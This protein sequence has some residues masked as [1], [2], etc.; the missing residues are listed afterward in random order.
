[1]IRRRTAADRAAIDAAVAAGMVTVYPPSTAS[2]GDAGM[3]VGDFLFDV[4]IKNARI[5]REMRRCGITSANELARRSGA[6]NSDVGR[7]LGLKITPMMS[8]RNG[9]VTWRGVVVKV[10]DALGVAPED[11]FS[12]AQKYTALKNNRFYVE[13][14]EAEVGMMVSS[15]ERDAEPPDEIIARREAAQIVRRAIET[16]TP[17]EAKVLGARYDDEETLEAV[18]A[19]QGVTKERIRQL[20]LK[21]I[22]KLRH[23]ARSNPLGAAADI[24]AGKRG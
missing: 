5:A 20:E 6:N 21:A 14:S 3:V 2:D 9:G 13:A 1:M 18:A 8:L 16:L 24:F 22:R 7:L 11:L 17:R 15:M 12:D 19:A 10:A 23:P 4:R